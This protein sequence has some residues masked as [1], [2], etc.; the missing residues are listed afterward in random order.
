MNNKTIKLRIGVATIIIGLIMVIV[1]AFNVKGQDILA[2]DSEIIAENVCI[3]KISTKTVSDEKHEKVNS[4]LKSDQPDSGIFE[5]AE[6]EES[7]KLEDW[8]LEVNNE[9][10][11]PVI[12]EL[13]DDIELEDWMLDLTLWQ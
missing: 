2:V 10:W 13:E 3:N 12:E 4:E 5:E 6:E 7:I 11:T 1:S 8:M 9:Y